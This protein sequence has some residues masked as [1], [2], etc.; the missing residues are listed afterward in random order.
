MMRVPFRLVWL[1]VAFM[2]IGCGAPPRAP[3]DSAAGGS[4]TARQAGPKRIIAATIGDPFTVYNKL[5]IGNS[6]RG[7]AEIERMVH[8]GLTV[9]DNTGQ[10]RPQMAEAVPSV[11]NG[12]WRLL[13]NGAMETVWKI[14]EGA[15]WHDGTPLTA[16]D[17]VFTFKVV[18]DRD[19][20]TFRDR[21][22]TSVDS[23][24]AVDARTVLARWKRPFIAADNLF[25]DATGMPLPRHILESALE[26]KS[27][28]TQ[29][30]YFS[31]Q[32]V[33]LGPFKLKEWARSSHIVVQANDQ[34]VL[35][36]PKVDEI[37][38]RTIP[39][40]NAI[41][42]N[43]LAGT[44]DL[45]LA[46]SLSIDQSL[47][48]REHWRDG[49]VGMPVSSLM[50]LYPQLLNPTPP[51]VA[52]LQFR[53]AVLHGMDRQ[54]L[55][56]GIN[57]GMTPP[58]YG[59]MEPDR[60]EYK[61]TESA[62]V[63]YEYDPARSFQLMDGLGLTRGPDGMYRDTSGQPIHLELRATS[64][65]I[66]TKTM[67]VVADMLKRIGLSADSVI[68]PQQRVDD[69]EY[70]TNFPSFTVNGQP[71]DLRMF[72]RFH[73][74]QARLPENN[75]VGENRSRYMNPE[76]DGLIDRYLVTIPRT[77]RMEL[78]RQITRHITE[79]LP[80][81]PLFYDSW[82]TATAGRLVNVGPA[83]AGG[84]AAWNAH[85]WDVK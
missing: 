65:D 62:I 13:P 49:T 35:G 46:R 36:R 20:P 64:G 82:P 74:N 47:Q 63:R 67:Y 84:D 19:L 25:S 27:T 81:M 31:T 59:F 30:G 34:Y 54:A 80:L 75:Y 55:A 23:V 61:E 60:A 51:I 79:N 85:E 42:A 41:V 52:D 18:S 12:N 33:G 17:F 8:A 48:L 1:I 45:V 78:A 15:V 11:E 22:Y 4:S 9:T 58:A 10:L 83:A 76:L 70:R 29:H 43:V 14:R 53:R 37:E 40:S 24:E 73:S 66:N 71:I 72:E 7:I 5:N 39:D 28:F 68:I 3:A 56:D 50:M 38:I 2:A 6:V 77:E 16:D 21:S 26:D 69:Q 32:F 57:Y 44:V